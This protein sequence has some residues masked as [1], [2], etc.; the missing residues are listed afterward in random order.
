MLS[1]ILHSFVAIMKINDN[2]CRVCLRIKFRE[3]IRP[4]ISKTSEG[5]SFLELIKYATGI[6]L[7]LNSDFPE[8]ICKYCIKQLEAAATIKT[9]CMESNERLV[10]L[11]RNFENLVLRHRPDYKQENEVETE[12]CV[13]D[14]L[15]VVIDVGH[16]NMEVQEE[17]I[18]D[19][20]QL[21]EGDEVI[22][23]E[24]RLYLND[25]EIEILLNS[26]NQETV[27]S[28]EETD[29][30][31]CDACGLTFPDAN[32]LTNHIRFDHL[33]SRKQC[34][35]CKEYFLTSIGLQIHMKSHEKPKRREKKFACS[36]CSKRYVTQKSLD[37][38]FGQKCGPSI[39][40]CI[41]CFHGFEKRNQLVHHLRATT[42]FAVDLTKD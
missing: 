10:D 19:V 14:N 31:R 35:I 20:E 33:N 5:V 30:F 9:I 22:K 1:Q 25:N 13:T 21:D 11:F 17:L 4:L 27:V 36:V 41:N 40:H 15:E 16:E 2:S 3:D 23:V 38:H 34:S 6:E 39:F 37:K 29:R 12:V 8:K 7:T 18:I 28:V 26:Q 24:P 42:N 32:L